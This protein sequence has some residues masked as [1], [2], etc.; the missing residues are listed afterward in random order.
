MPPRK[1]L[2]RASASLQFDEMAVRPIR[3]GHQ[4]IVVA[5]VPD[6]AI[7]QKDNAI[8][9]ANR[10]QAMGESAFSDPRCSLPSG[11]EP[12]LVWRG[13]VLGTDSRSPWL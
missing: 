6:F 10:R 9:L 11:G 1:I 2:H 4:R 8:R 7:L 3:I 13:G 5:N 12:V